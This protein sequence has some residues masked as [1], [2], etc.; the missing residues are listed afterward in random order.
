MAILF[1]INNTDLT[2]WEDRRD[3]KVNREEIFETWTDGNWIEHRVVT[4][5]RVSGSLKL[6]FAREADYSAFLALL[7]SERTA[8][9][10]YPITVWCDNTGGTVE[11][12]A[13]LTCTGV[14]NWD[15]TAP[16]KHQSITVT[17][18]Q[19]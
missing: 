14:V 8:D 12:N 16:I 17:I 3:H 10:Y 13:F 19:R 18:A 5:T 4:R 7:V 1:K 11:I 15:V 2:R 6:N 9:G